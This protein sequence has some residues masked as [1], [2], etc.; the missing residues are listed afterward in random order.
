MGA[1]AIAA[2]SFLLGLLR[3]ITSSRKS[4][5][6]PEGLASRCLDQYSPIPVWVSL[7]NGSRIYVGYVLNTVQY[8]LSVL[9]KY[10]KVDTFGHIPELS[11]KIRAVA[12]CDHKPVSI[13]S[14]ISMLFEFQKAGGE[15]DWYLYFI[16]SS[17]SALAP[18]S[19]GAISGKEGNDAQS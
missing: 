19:T 12:N 8:D 11:E 3:G 4:K 6:P 16:C 9:E 17:E 14:I 1:V 7:V 13:R 15:P 18:D 2:A 5:F 10:G